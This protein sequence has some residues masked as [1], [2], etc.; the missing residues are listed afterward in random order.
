MN[1]SQKLNTMTI[2][3]LRARGV[4]LTS[5]AKEAEAQGNYLGRQQDLLRQ[6]LEAFQR[7]AQALGAISTD[8]RVLRALAE[9][10]SGAKA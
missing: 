9:T 8:L 5:Q 6:E 4:R 10:A 1:K 2:M 7:M 3:K